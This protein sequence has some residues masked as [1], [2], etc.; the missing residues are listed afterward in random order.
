LCSVASYGGL[1]DKIVVCTPGR[2]ISRLH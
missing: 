2:T 1:G